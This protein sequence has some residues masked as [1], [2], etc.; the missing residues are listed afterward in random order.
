[1]KKTLDLMLALLLA[2]SLL[3]P[4]SAFALEAQPSDAE[5][6]PVLTEISF[7]NAVINEEFSPFNKDYTI[8]LEDA[9]L[10][11]TLKS[12]TI[13]G[14]ASIFVTYTLDEAKHQTGIVATLEFEGGTTIY[15][16]AYS[17]A[18]AYA[19]SSNNLLSEVTVKGGLGEV[20]PAINDKDTDYRLYIPSDLGVLNITATTQDVSAYCDLPAEI[21]LSAD[22]EAKISATVTASNGETRTYSFKIKRL[23]KSCDE[24]RAEIAAADFETLVKGELF[25]QKPAFIITLCAV[26]G[27]LLLLIIFIKLAKRLMIKAEDADEKDF[28]AE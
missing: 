24:V 27:G 9:S 3:A 19:E 5:T 2:I 20:Y 16:F 11:P 12:Y 18:Q 4:A 23:D 1:M 22:Q 8:T 6:T 15:N 14:S 13:D 10:T 26:A 17:N 28:F 25:Y 7:K 21:T